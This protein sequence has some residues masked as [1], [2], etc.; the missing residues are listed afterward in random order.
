MRFSPSPA[1]AAPSHRT[2]GNCNHL[3]KRSFEIRPNLRYPRN[4]TI[5]SE[6]VICTW[7]LSSSLDVALFLSLILN[8][9]FPACTA[10]HHFYWPPPP[11]GLAKHT[12]GFKSEFVT[13]IK[14]G[15]RG[16]AHKG[17]VDSGVGVG[18]DRGYSARHVLLDPF[19]GRWFICYCPWQYSVCACACG[20]WMLG[21]LLSLS[22]CKSFAVDACTCDEGLFF[23]ES[24][25][26]TLWSS[27]AR[28]RARFKISMP[29][30]FINPA[31]T[32]DGNQC[33]SFYTTLLK[34]VCVHPSCDV[35]HAWRVRFSNKYHSSSPVYTWYY[36]S[37]VFVIV[38]VVCSSKVIR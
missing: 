21:G 31:E 27:V 26:L 32:A 16:G 20:M 17:A 11:A 10:S 13:L 22:K 33:V 18:L 1:P 14:L 8:C 15:W 3:I 9:G 34:K 35:A 25:W 2:S 19:I 37:F 7:F 29:K 23:F 12:L 4:Y 38:T 24:A 30:G 5:I 36:S 6:E 28:H